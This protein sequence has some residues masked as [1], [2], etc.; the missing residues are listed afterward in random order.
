MEAPMA[1]ASIRQLT[2]QELGSRTEELRAL[3]DDEWQGDDDSTATTGRTPWGA[4]TS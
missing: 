2:T 3:F 1:D 4:P